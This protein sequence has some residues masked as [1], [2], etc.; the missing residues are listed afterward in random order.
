MNDL[1]HLNATVRVRAKYECSVCH[2]LVEGSLALL[3]INGTP[4]IVQQQIESFQVSPAHRPKDWSRVL[5]NGE[6][7]YRCPVHKFGGQA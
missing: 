1:L 4:R 7:V 6:K 3:E 2:V 5:D